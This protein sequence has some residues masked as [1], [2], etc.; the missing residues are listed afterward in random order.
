MQVDNARVCPTLGCFNFIS[1]LVVSFKDHAKSFEVLSLIFLL[2]LLW[3]LADKLYIERG[4]VEN[5]SAELSLF[6]SPM[7]QMYLTRLLWSRSPCC[8]ICYIVCIRSEY[9]DHRFGFWLCFQSGRVTLTS[10][11]IKNKVSRNHKT[12]YPLVSAYR[13]IRTPAISL[14]CQS[15]N[16]SVYLL[17]VPSF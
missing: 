2:N 6:R 15:T 17:P 7:M 4:V 14:G 8:T 16:V 11:Y 3:R 1:Q 9:G 5:T 12:G 10:L 13:R